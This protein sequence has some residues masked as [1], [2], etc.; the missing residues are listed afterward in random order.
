MKILHIITQKPNST[1][2]GVY[3]CGMINGFKKMGYNQ[4]VIAGIDK[5][6]NIKAFTDDISYYPVIYNS[7]E[8]PFNVVGMSD[9]MPYKS[10][11]YRDM[12]LD[13][14]N[15]LKNDFKKKYKKSNK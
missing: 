15:M 4:A 3:M 11:R 7:D 5:D 12:D 6:D 14:V 2:S 1:G 9:V 8:L 13:M 10:T